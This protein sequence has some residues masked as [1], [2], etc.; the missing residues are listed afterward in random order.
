MYY[1]LIKDIVSLI[2]I[3]IIVKNVQMFNVS[4]VKEDIILIK[5]IILN[6][7]RKIHVM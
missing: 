5:L 6:N 2:V 4:N 1:L 3:L 7:V